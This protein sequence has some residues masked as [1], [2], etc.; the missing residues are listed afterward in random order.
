MTWIMWVDNKSESTMW[1]FARF[2]CSTIFDKCWISDEL[3]CDKEE[4]NDIQIPFWN[5]SCTE[6]LH[7]IQIRSVM[8]ILELLKMRWMSVGAYWNMSE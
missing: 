5:K 2:K 4:K 7:K 8:F 3:K 1:D 6:K